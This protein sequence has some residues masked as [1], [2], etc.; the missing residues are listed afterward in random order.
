[1]LLNNFLFHWKI[2]YNRINYGNV[3]DKERN[4]YEQVNTTR[5]GVTFMEITDILRGSVDSSDYKGYI[6]GLLFLKRLSDTFEE[7]KRNQISEHGEEIGSLLA[8]DPD[9]HQFFVPI[10][11]KWEEIRKHAEDIGSAINVAFEALEN[12]NA[13]LEGVLTPIDFNRKEV[14]KDSTS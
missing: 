4:F 14:L 6:F 12:E 7:K 11:A 9:Q 5:V 2:D 1:M 10:V 3:H 13:T 8:D